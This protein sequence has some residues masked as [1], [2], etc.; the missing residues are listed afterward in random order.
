MKTILGTEAGSASTLVRKMKEE[1][2]LDDLPES[3]RSSVSQGV[4]MSLPTL[5]NKLGGHGQGEEVVSVPRPYAELAVGL[6]ACLTEAT[7]WASPYMDRPFTILGLTS[8]S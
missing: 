5:R 6:A 7:R 3:V 2:Y 8:W 1:G 4:L